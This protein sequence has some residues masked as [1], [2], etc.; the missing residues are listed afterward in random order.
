MTSSGNVAA[1]SIGR[2]RFSRSRGSRSGRVVPRIV[3]IGDG[4]LRLSMHLTPK[5]QRR[6]SESSAARARTSHRRFFY[7]ETLELE[8]WVR[9]CAGLSSSLLE[10]QPQC[11][12]EMG[13]GNHFELF[14]IEPNAPSR[15]KAK[16]L[17][18]CTDFRD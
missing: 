15:R 13:S 17:H 2:L 12:D 4:T 18:V 3:A 1:A 14:A 11:F 5:V 8:C 7:T 9:E 16:T 10:L 6:I